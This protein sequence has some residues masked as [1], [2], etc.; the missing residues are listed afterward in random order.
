MVRNPPQ[1]KETPCV[2]A[3]TGGRAELEMER[4]TATDHERLCGPL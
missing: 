2:K 4:H 1:A 3:V